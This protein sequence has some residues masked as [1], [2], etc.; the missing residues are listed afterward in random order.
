MGVENNIWVES[1]WADL[2]ECVY[3]SPSVWV[4]PKFLSDARLRAQGEFGEFWK[5]NGG[6]DVSVVAPKVFQELSNQISETIKILEAYG[7]VVLTAKAVSEKNRLF[8]RGED[9]GVSTPWMRDPF[10]TIGNNVIELAPRSLF[11]RRQRFAVREILASLGFK[12]LNEII[13]R[14]DLL[15]QV[16]KGSSDLDDLDLNPLFVQALSL[17]HI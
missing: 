10:V 11:H 5:L 2:K 8:P 9:H 7:V 16:S 15:K 13:G 6:Q 14:T 4:L 17:I 3:G 1:E 12:S